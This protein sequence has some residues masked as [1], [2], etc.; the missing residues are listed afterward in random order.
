MPFTE[1]NT[2]SVHLPV[3]EGY[4]KARNI[5]IQTRYLYLKA[6]EFYEIKNYLFL[7]NSPKNSYQAQMAFSRNAF[8]EHWKT[9]EDTARNY[10]NEKI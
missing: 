10:F 3:L 4:L 1:I 7:T 8:P 6:A 2:P 9:T 5:K